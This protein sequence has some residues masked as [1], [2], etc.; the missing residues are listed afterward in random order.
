MFHVQDLPEG[1]GI[2]GLI[3]LTFLRRFNDE[4]DPPR[5]ASS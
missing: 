1:W 5:G 2:E 3:G 4:I